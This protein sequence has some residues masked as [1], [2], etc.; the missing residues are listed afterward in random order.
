V[1]GRLLSGLTTA[2][3]RHTLLWPPRGLL[4][5]LSPPAQWL[6]RRLVWLLA[7]CPQRA[8]PRGWCFPQFLPLSTKDTRD[9]FPG[10]YDYYSRKA[11]SLQCTHLLLCWPLAVQPPRLAPRSRPGGGERTPRQQAWK[12][13]QPLLCWVPLPPRT[14]PSI[15]CTVHNRWSIKYDY[16][17][18]CTTRERS[19]L[20]SLTGQQS[21]SERLVC[22][23]CRQA[24]TRRAPPPRLELPPVLQQQ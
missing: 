24:R 9:Q 14:S 19:S 7:Q 6:L 5:W 20:T 8:Q 17:A 22:W 12:I 11:A 2:V 10:G 4:R 13:L 15:S 1:N 3:H 16:Q 21:R 23:Q 18:I